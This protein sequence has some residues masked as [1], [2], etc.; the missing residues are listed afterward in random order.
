MRKKNDTIS[1]ATQGIMLNEPLLQ[2]GFNRDGENMFPPTH[3]HYHHRF[4]CHR[5]KCNKL[6]LTFR[7]REL[8]LPITRKI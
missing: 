5:C 7:P 3:L 2:N 8:N 4:H 6:Y 1:S